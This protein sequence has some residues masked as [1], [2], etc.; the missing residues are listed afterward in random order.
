MSLFDPDR[1]RERMRTVP[2]STLGGYPFVGNQTMVSTMATMPSPLVAK[3]SEG[4]G[5]IEPQVPSHIQTLVLLE[6]LGLTK[7]YALSAAVDAIVRYSKTG[8]DSDLRCAKDYIEH[9]LT[10]DGEHSAW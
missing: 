10:K 3:P 6:Q 8:N 5:A 7:N 1:L 9:L 4:Y 2:T